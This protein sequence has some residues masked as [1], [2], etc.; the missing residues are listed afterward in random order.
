MATAKSFTELGAIYTNSVLRES[1]NSNTNDV[2]TE[3]DASKPKQTVGKVQDIGTPKLAKEGGDEKV[4][5]DLN[6]P[7]EAKSPNGELKDGEKELSQNLKES[8]HMS[9]KSLFNRVYEQIVEDADE[10]NAGDETANE[11]EI[12]SADAEGADAEGA[13]DELEGA[14]V[15]HGSEEGELETAE[16]LIN[17]LEHVLCQLKKHFGIECNYGTD[18]AEVGGETEGELELPEGD[19]EPAVGEAVDAKGLPDSAGKSLQSKK[20]NVGGVKVVNRKA[21]SK[22]TTGDGKIEKAP[23]GEKLAGNKNNKVQVSGSAQ[24]GSNASA[25]ES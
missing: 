4:K 24:R 16:E 22:S 6:K 23:D 25:F 21:D 8:K 9:K 17:H 11:I 12:A 18:E 13:E 5:K 20:N 3:S 7:K 1:N 10:F 15:D 2:I 14:E 19:E